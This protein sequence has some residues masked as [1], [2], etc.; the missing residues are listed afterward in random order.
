MEPLPEKSALARVVSREVTND[1]S[2]NVFGSDRAQRS[3][4]ESHPYLSE[5]QSQLLI[6][7]YSLSPEV[8]VEEGGLNSYFPCVDGPSPDAC[9]DYMSP[10]ARV[11]FSFYSREEK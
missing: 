3:F 7:Y 6:L 4:K 5:K 2:L 1:C 11:P 8:G 9:R 10:V